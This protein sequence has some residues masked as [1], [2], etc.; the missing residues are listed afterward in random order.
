MD[1]LHGRKDADV[2]FDVVR[3][4]IHLER[5]KPPRPFWLAWQPP[6]QIPDSIT[7]T[8]ET[9][10]LAYT[11]RWPVEPGIRFRKQRLGWT[12]PRFR[13]KETGDR[14]SWLVALSLWL[15]FFARPIV[16]G[17]PLPW[18]KPQQHLTPQRVQQGLPL[19]FGQF[20]GPARAPKRRGIPPGWRKGR[21][22]TPK[23]RFKGGKKQP[24]VA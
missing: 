22:R 7:V 10:W 4:S 13:H 5:E 3:A 18:Q 20:G 19:I 9:I 14:W 1:N 12:T 17:N 11:H 21:R 16:Q 6:P 23:P 2:P 8:A 24:A 15:L